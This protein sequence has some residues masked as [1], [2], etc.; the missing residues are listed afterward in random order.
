MTL[1]FLE[2][3]LVISSTCFAKQRV[4]S[5]FTPRRVGLG[6]WSRSWSEMK[7]VG[8]QFYSFDSVQKKQVTHLSAFNDSFH[9]LLHT[10][11]V[12]TRD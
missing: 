1:S 2:A 10:A 7:M 11:T 8:A 9:V 3:V 12:S 5:S 4:L 6:S